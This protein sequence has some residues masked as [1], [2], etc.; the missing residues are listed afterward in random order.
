[1]RGSRKIRILGSLVFFGAAVDS[2][3]ALYQE[4]QLAGSVARA[5]G[6]SFGTGQYRVYG[7][8]A[9]ARNDTVALE[10]DLDAIYGDYGYG[11]T[12]YVRLGAAAKGHIFDYQNL[13]HIVDSSTGSENKSISLNSPFWR[14]SPYVEARYRSWS[15]RYSAGAQQ[16]LLSAR[17]KSNAL[18]QVESPAVAF[19][20]T[21]MVGYWNINQL[22]PYAFTGTALF[23]MSESSR[24]SSTYTWSLAGA[25][26]TKPRSDVV[27][28][29]IHARHGGAIFENSLKVMINLRGGA[30]NFSLP[31]ESVDLLQSFSVGGPETRYRRVAGYSFS[32]FRAPAFGIANLDSIWHLVGAMNLWAIVDVAVFDREFNSRRLHAG[33]GVGFIFDLPDGFIGSRSA[34]FA[35][36][37]V[38]FFAAGG[39]RFQFFM[40]LNG[41]IF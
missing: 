12:Q 10:Y 11:I 28:H 30:T 24:Q 19:F 2:T 8:E 36:I 6:Y 38:P 7:T 14:A 15:L 21:A 25:P 18:L 34:I 1:M 13:N 9:L 41:Q 5:P 32:E 40:G 27:I 3:Y 35:R 4:Y 23:V 39:D 22:K 33:A 26:I 37:E 31:G 17:D 20:Q 29:E 16:F